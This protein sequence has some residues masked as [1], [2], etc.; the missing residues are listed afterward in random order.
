MDM[1]YKLEDMPL[2]AR[3][4]RHVAYPTVKKGASLSRKR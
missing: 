4:P 3:K 1:R 2:S